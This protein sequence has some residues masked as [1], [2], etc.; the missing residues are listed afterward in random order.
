M[1]DPSAPPDRFDDF[2]Q[3]SNSSFEDARLLLFYGCSGSG[4][5]STLD[6]LARQH[7]DFRDRPQCHLR[8]ES[9]PDRVPEVHS[10]VVF[11]DEI[12]RRRELRLVRRLLRNCNTVV[13]AT[14]VAPVWF[15]P[16][17]RFGKLVAYRTD[18]DAT[19]IARYLQR[20]GVDYSDAVVRNYCRRYGATFTDVDCILEAW[21]SCS[22][23]RSFYHFHR[24]GVIVSEPALGP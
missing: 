13:A 19:K 21:P 20:L 1:T 3:L 8:W 17:R 4:K 14:H 10:H 23:D 12:R 6:F 9:F 15:W 11:L 16:L 18:R 22:F 2:L 24:H 7:A 5:S